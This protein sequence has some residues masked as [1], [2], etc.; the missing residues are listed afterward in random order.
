[1]LAGFFLGDSVGFEEWRLVQQET[2]HRQAV[3]ILA[4]LAAYHEARNEYD[5][6]QRYAGQLVALEPWHEPGRLWLMRALAYAGQTAAALE[7]YA[8][9]RQVLAEEFDLGPSAEAT[10]LF[11]Q[12]QAGQVR[13]RAA[14]RP[15]PGQASSNAVSPANLGDRRPVTAL[16]CGH[17]NPVSHDDPEE[18]LHRLAVCRPGCQVIF[19]RYGGH[20]HQR[21]GTQCLI[22]FGYPVAHEDAARRAVH[23]GLA[24][25]KAATSTDHAHAIGIHTSAMVSVAG[26]LVGDAPDL[27]RGCQELAA[28]GTVLIT[29]DTERLARGWFRCQEL[30]PKTLPGRADPVVVYQALGESDIHS[31]LDW[32]AQTQSLTAFVGRERKLDQLL[33]FSDE[34]RGGKGRAVLISGAPGIGKSRLLREFRS[35]FFQKHL[36]ESGTWLESRCSPY[37]HNTSLYPIIGLLEQLLG[38]EASDSPE[39]KR[40]KFDR[41]LARCDLARPAANWLLSLLLGLPTDEPAPQTITANQRERMREML[42]VLLQK[43]AALQPLVLVIED[44]H[45]S[46]PTTVE[47]LG[48]SFD[49]LAAA[50]CLVLLTCRPTFVS[51][52]LPRE[53]LLSLTLGPLNPAQA[54][55]VV[56]SVVGDRELPDEV[57]QRI[58]EQ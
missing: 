2:L 13:K 25:V 14:S 31:R 7:Q 43:Q 41:T 58:V 50:P 12:I 23:A 27:S 39:V 19:D 1:L 26:E 44:L 34:A 32:L 46:D 5:L 17:R 40:D 30:G 29:A 47:W 8:G 45:W 36:A 37:F 52:W 11:E 56:S 22:Y 16:I 38:F 55:S 51:P 10:A 49:A 9:Y 48:Q 21:Q 54:E 28:P 33:A 18:L 53:H 42:V 6:V 20:C 15:A 3:E 4:R 35:R 57:C 24:M